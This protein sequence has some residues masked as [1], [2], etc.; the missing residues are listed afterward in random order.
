MLSLAG[1]AT[2][3]SEVVHALTNPACFSPSRALAFRMSHATVQTVSH[4][5]N[6]HSHSLS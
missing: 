4:S 6:L 5:Q 1:T 3:D 2:F